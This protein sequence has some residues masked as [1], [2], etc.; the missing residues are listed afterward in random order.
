M[1]EQYGPPES[2]DAPP[3]GVPSAGQPVPGPRTPPSP[4]R[5]QRAQ[6][7][8]AVPRWLGQLP[9]VFVLCGVAAG[10]A[11]VATDH[12]RRGSMLIAAAVFIG[13]LARLVLPESQ[14]GMLAVRRRWVDVLLMTAAAVGVTLVAFVAKGQ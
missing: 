13:A 2:Y 7:R 11:V 4:R 1:S 12:F 9:Y 5:A 14:T 10:L 8:P 6:A 3:A